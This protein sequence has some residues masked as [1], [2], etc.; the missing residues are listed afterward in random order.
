MKNNSLLI[1][2]SPNWFPFFVFFSSLIL[3]V[4]AALYAH[5]TLDNKARQRF[6]TAISETVDAI[7]GRVEAYVTLLRGAG[8]L[9]GSTPKISREKF[10]AYMSR[11]Q[12]PLY[13]PGA[14]GFGWAPRVLPREKEAMTAQMQREGLTRFKIWPDQS[15]R[16]QY[17]IVFLEPQDR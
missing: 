11:L 7:E 4:V 1:E 13:Y 3:T 15:G 2:R 8:G 10:Q 9:I 14:Q 5:K 6:E 16:E 12:L 17:P